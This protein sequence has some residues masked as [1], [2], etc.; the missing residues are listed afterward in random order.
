MERLESGQNVPEACWP[1]AEVNLS[2][3]NIRYPQHDGNPR[4]AKTT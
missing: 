4:L 1:E 2:S 3:N